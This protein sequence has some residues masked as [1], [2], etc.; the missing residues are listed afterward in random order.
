[1][2]FGPIETRYEHCVT[3]GQPIFALFSFLAI[4]NMAAVQTSEVTATQYR[5]LM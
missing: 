1:M 5:H 3:I 4:T 2:T